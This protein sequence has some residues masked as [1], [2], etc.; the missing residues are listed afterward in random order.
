MGGSRSAPGVPPLPPGL[1]CVWVWAFGSLVPP[2]SWGPW[3]PL[4]V[5]FAYLA[6]FSAWRV[7]TLVSK[8]HRLPWNDPP[9]HYLYCSLSPGEGRGGNGISSGR[10][11]IHGW[12]SFSSRM[13]FGIERKGTP[14]N[15]QMT[16]YV[17]LEV[18]HIGIQ[19]KSTQPQTLAPIS[20]LLACG[21]MLQHLFVPWFNFVRWAFHAFRDTPERFRH[22]LHYLAQTLAS[23]S[24]PGDAV[25]AADTWE[26]DYI[27]F[28]VALISFGGLLFLAG[29]FCGKWQ[30]QTRGNVGALAHRRE[31]SATTSA[32]RTRISTPPTM[33]RS[34]STPSP[35]RLQQAF[36]PPLGRRLEFPVPLSNQADLRSAPEA[37]RTK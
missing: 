22:W 17:R 5:A 25:A 32:D 36:L 30:V 27:I 11:Q 20:I 9:P 16:Y 26:D 19:Q 18:I 15:P 2:R 6:R 23:V 13:S 4:L 28:N 24:A 37:K 14:Q 1:C 7:C 35:L 21:S 10:D 34:H 29:F 8:S 31:G 33:Q 3:G 12:V